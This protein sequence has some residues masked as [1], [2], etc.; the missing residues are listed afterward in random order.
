MRILV[1]GSSGYI[2]SRWAQMLRAIGHEVIG[3]DREPPIVELDHSIVADLTVPATY[4]R[5][6]VGVD[7]IHHLAAAKGDWG[8]NEA[9]YD[10]DN[11][12]ATALLIEVARRLGIRQWLYYSTVAV[13]GPTDEALDETAP[14][15]PNHPYGES[16]AQAEILIDAFCREDGACV[17]TIRP[18][19]VFGPENP[20]NTNIFRLMEAIHKRRFIMVGD[21]RE[22]KTTSYIE[23]LLAATLHVFQTCLPGPAGQHALFHYVDTPTQSTSQIVA[24]IHQALD[25]SPGRLRLPMW[26]AAGIA[27]VADAAA[28]VTRIDLPI[29]S[30]RIQKFGTS[31][32]FAA[33]RIRSSGFVQPVDM[34]TAMSRTADWYRSVYLPRRNDAG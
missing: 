15:A 25:I 28:A 11:R 13:L 18:S 29:T 8:I 9:E 10:R 31:T 21:G 6:L 26:F 5:Q 20:W 19:V 2:G 16:K 14:M 1:T 34:P 4:E 12:E 27:K 23:N 30:A 32:N 17:A 22:V 24:T 33:E 7:Q 3:L